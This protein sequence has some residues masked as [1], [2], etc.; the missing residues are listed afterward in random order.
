M[1]S[2]ELEEMVCYSPASVA[3]HASCAVQSIYRHLENDLIKREKKSEEP[4]K[5]PNAFRIGAKWM[6]P[7]EDAIKFLG[8]DPSK[9]KVRLVK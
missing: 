2:P 5:F 6:I 7:E 3:E 8:Y 4:L 9:V 1:A